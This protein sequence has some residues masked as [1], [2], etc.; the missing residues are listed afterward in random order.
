MIPATII[1]LI[2]NAALLLA[3]ALLYD[4]FFIKSSDKNPTSRR[5]INGLLI[6]SIGV[7]IMLTPVEFWPG[8]VFDTR[9]VLLSI[10]G[11]FFGPIPTVVAIIMTSAFRIHLGGVGMWMGIAV[12]FSSGAIGMLWRHVRKTGLA[13]ISIMEFYALGIVVH[14][15]MLMFMLLLPWSAL[16]EVLFKIGIPVM[17]IYPIGTALLGQLMLNRHNRIQTET[18]LVQIKS[19]TEN[20]LNAQNDTFFV[21]DPASRKAIWWNRSFKEQSGY[22]DEEIAGMKAPDS[23]YSSEDLKK[24]ADAIDEMWKKGKA[25]VEIFLIAK[26]GK[27]IPF[28]YSISPVISND[29]GKPYII[30]IGRDVSERKK[31][32]SALKKSEARFRAITSTAE[33]PI[34][35]KDANRRYTFVNPAMTR[36][37][38]YREE[39]LIGKTPEEIF[40]A[41]SAAIIKEVDDRTFD[42]EKVNEIRTLKVNDRAFVFN[43]IQVPME[44]REGKVV[45][46]SGIVRNISDIITAQEEKLKLEAQLRQSQKLESIGILSGGIAHDFNNL[47][48]VISGNTELI[49]N[50]ASP[51]IEESLK[52]VLN[53]TQRGSELVQQLLTFSRKSETNLQTVSLNHEIR[54]IHRMLERII[55]KMIEIRLDLADDLYAVDADPGQI[56]QVLMNLS[57]N[58]RDAMSDTGRL[59]IQTE[60][61]AYNNRKSVIL[62]V[63]DTG[64]GMD[65]ETREKIF[66]PFFTTK[67]IGKGSGLGLSVIYGIIK[68]H[69]GDIFCDSVME[70]GTT[71]TIYLPAAKG[72]D[73]C[74]SETPEN[75]TP[76][77]GRETILVVDDDEIVLKLTQTILETLG[78]ETIPA[79][80]GETAL[81]IYSDQG[82]NIDLVVLDLGM[83][84]MGGA[85]CLE[86]LLQ[87]NPS[88]KVVIASGYTEDGLIKDSLDHGAKA[89][90]VK[91]YTI[92]KFSKVIRTVLSGAL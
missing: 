63:S 5:L 33:D 56:E 40:D 66:D 29:E 60:N 65:K 19:F 69:N 78:Y 20:A 32:E 2:N 41:D 70:A 49:L 73:I 8:L 27:T 58:A 7:V 4:I 9:S 46:I 1:G 21:L 35:C 68:A 89:S 54:R 6:G 85:N 72:M 84:G 44:I 91:P 45:S 50:N 79:K 76:L 13:H 77:R 75:K 87:M 24:T 55:P 17:I 34:F 47:L 23:Y 15:V 48:Y 26:N 80:S 31:A 92:E 30:A 16:L 3:L 28:E 57:L 81:E 61:G 83:P 14:A 37:F 86:K 43:T 88:V 10:S 25:T 39:A 51:K 62:K 53:A 64:H 11:F 52:H 18:E 42:G 38:G 90:I 71:F 67:E 59:L 36:I 74:R 22:T 82:N 12:I